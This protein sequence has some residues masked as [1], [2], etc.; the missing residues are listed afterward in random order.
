[1]PKS[2]LLYVVD[3]D[4]SVRSSVSFALTNAGWNVTAFETGEQFVAMASDLV[5]AP[6]LLDLDLE[7]FD[8]ISVLRALALRSLRFPVI[9]MIGNAETKTIVASMRAGATDFLLKPFSSEDLLAT[10]RCAASCYNN[11]VAFEA[12]VIEAS[13]KLAALSQGEKDVLVRV[14]QGLTNLEIAK[15]LGRTIHLVEVQK[16]QIM[17]K[18]KVDSFACVLRIAF[19]ADCGAFLNPLPIVRARI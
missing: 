3:D 8:G 1:M 11:H 12:R 7:G 19:V 5:I 6:V 9:L 10:V 4:L 14:A 16:A 15:D 17:Q 18:M 13:Q 2:S